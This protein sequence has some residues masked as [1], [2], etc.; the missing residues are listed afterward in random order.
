MALWDPFGGHCASVFVLGPDGPRA[1]AFFPLPESVA[2]M[3]VKLHLASGRYY[4]LVAPGW[5]F[6]F[7]FPERQIINVPC[8]WIAY[9]VLP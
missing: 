7:P 4:T 1:L 8:A 5:P 2:S 9:P 6:A 3:T